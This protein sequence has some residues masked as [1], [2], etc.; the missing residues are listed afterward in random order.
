MLQMS[1][2]EEIKSIMQ[3]L[4]LEYE[5]DYT[6]DQ[7]FK[8]L[9]YGKVVCCADADVD[10]FHI[11][12]LL[13]NFFHDKFPSLLERDPSFFSKSQRSRQRHS[14]RIETQERI[15]NNVDIIIILLL[16]QY[17]SKIRRRRECCIVLVYPS[18]AHDEWRPCRYRWTRPA[19]CRRC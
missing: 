17:L 12:G 14:T 15:Y 13:L 5:T 18:P 10:G 4:G 19:S 8:K 2:C 9:N 3:I 7:N 11:C 6:I 1:G 16:L